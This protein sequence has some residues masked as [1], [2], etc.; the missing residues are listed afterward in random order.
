MAL[1]GSK[2]ENSTCVH[3]RPFC[4]FFGGAM[5][6]GEIRQQIKDVINESKKRR[7]S[8]A[9][10]EK[11]YQSDKKKIQN[12]PKISKNSQKYPE[13]DPK[14]SKIL[15]NRAK[16][17]E[18]GHEL[19]KIMKNSGGT[20]ENHEK[21][22]LEVPNG[23]NKQSLGY[24]ERSKGR[25]RKPDDEKIRTCS[26][27]LPPEYVKDIM[28]EDNLKKGRLGL[29]MRLRIVYD[30][31]RKY[32]DREDH[33]KK[34]L[35]QLFKELEDLVQDYTKIFN[36]NRGSED[37]I[38]RLKKVDSKVKQIITIKNIIGLT[39]DEFLMFSGGKN[40]SWAQYCMDYGNNS[41]LN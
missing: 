21:S 4:S 37:T 20:A 28:S 6:Q 10:L 17:L 18:I 39:Y 27:K 31:F 32:R 30:K 26:I 5:S 22:A 2:G 24:I 34:I 23:G 13:K 25:P 7:E 36:R 9:K 41:K 29:G 35:K 19:L 12:I 16:Q 14:T 3:I 33:Q 38:N 8:L 15:E 11:D 1:S 40:A